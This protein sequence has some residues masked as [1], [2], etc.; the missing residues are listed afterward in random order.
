M[1]KFSVKSEI[2]TPPI[3]YITSVILEN[4]GQFLVIS[5]ILQEGN[6]I[7]YK[8][9]SVLLENIGYFLIISIILQE[10][11]KILDT[12]TSVLLKNIGN[13][14]VFCVKLN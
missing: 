8:F 2:Y 14:K 7:L 5:I 12:F 13:V 10:G 9:T 3:F 4:I 1:F 6:K 11:N